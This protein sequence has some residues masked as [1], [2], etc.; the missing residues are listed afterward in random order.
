[1]RRAQPAH[2]SFSLKPVLS[3]WLRLGQR[4]QLDPLKECKP[5]VEQL[6][7]EH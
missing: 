2:F 4:S 6:E 7:H 5:E 3:R 1:M